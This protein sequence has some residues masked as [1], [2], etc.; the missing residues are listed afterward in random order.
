MSKHSH[1]LAYVRCEWE[2]EIRGDFLFY[3]ELRTTTT[4]KDV[5]DT[6][7]DF[8]RNNGINWTNCIGVCTESAAA[9]TGRHAGVVGAWV[10]TRLFS[11]REELCIFL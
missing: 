3:K 4:T 1:I 10:L 11:L 8:I 5:F 6:L 2:K 9:M 7:D